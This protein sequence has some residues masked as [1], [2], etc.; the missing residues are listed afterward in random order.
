M[1]LEEG[2]GTGVPGVEG[3]G[4]DG[5]LGEPL[6]GVPRC[7]NLRLRVPVEIDMAVKYAGFQLWRSQAR[8][9]CK[10][11]EGFVE[12]S[13]ALMKFQTIFVETL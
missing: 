9:R 3:V 11:S 13:T 7:M 6:S 12:N 4:V 2:A 1:N 10:T 5:P 8:I